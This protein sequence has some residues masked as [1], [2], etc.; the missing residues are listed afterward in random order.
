MVDI[1]NPITNEN[2]TKGLTIVPLKDHNNLLGY[3]H[4]I[5]GHKNYHIFH[6]KIISEENYWNNITDSCKTYIKECNIY[7]SKNKTTLLPLHVIKLFEIN[8]LNY[9]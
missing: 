4:F 8:L 3:Y 7:T 2:K 6:D 1:K 5:T 9:I